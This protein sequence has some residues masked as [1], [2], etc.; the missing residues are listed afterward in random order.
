MA[1][2]RKHAPGTNRK[3]AS[4]EALRAAGGDSFTL[5][6][7]PETNRIVTQLAEQTGQTKTAIINRLIEA[8]A[9]RD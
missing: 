6:L 4:R 5:A 7:S 8:A 2:P 9:P 3:A 1:R